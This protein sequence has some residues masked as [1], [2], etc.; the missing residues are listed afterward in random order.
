MTRYSRNF[1]VNAGLVLLAVIAIAA[2]CMAQTS[3]STNT[4]TNANTNSSP[5]PE[6]TK[7]PSN[8]IVKAPP[9]AEDDSVSKNNAEGAGAGTS[10]TGSTTGSAPPQKGIS[11]LGDRYQ[12]RDRNAPRR[13]NLEAFRLVKHVNA[14]FSGFD[15]GAGLGLGIELTSA[16][17]IPGVEFRGKF[18]I[19]T[20]FYRRFEVE[21]YFPKVVDE[22]THADVWFTYIHRLRD[23]F[24]GIGPRTPENPETNYASEYRLYNASLYRDF[25]ENLQ[26]GIY[27]SVT[28]SNAYRGENE[29]EIPINVLYSNNPNVI[30]VT[31]WLPGLNTNAKLLAY[32]AFVEY[33][34]R[35]NERGLTKGAYFYARFGSIDGLDNDSFSDFGWNEVSLDGRAYLPLGSD[36]TSIAVRAYTELLNP[37]GGSQIPFYL[38]PW[39]GGRSHGRG[40]VNY[41]FRGNNVLLF[42][43]EPR[44]TVWK[45][46]ETKGLD[47]F[48]FGDGGQVW[49][50]SRST[51]NPQVVANN[52]FDA[53][54][55]RFG[56][57][58]GV[59]YR[60]NK[61]FAVRVDIA[62]SNETNRVYFS[63]SRGF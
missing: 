39:Y 27:T 46:S 8:Y 40:F 11:Q 59:Q 63:L 7:V 36:F 21:A 45:Q 41:R 52:N 47:V 10:N 30:P 32:G 37:K 28:N 15:Q 48:A 6:I 62:T 44:R 4:G 55:W 29:D 22:Q 57:G 43:I 51:T 17:T 16:D 13:D 31:R 2:Q 20:R 9:L 54:N 53:S 56:I 35:D 61:S 18:L 26:A 58:G 1:W 14:L 49:G 25:T 33:N 19:S 3:S 50:D 60:L 5:L 38:M 24:F 12:S 42:C 34:G 23:N